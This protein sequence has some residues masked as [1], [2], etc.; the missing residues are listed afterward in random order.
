MAWHRSTHGTPSGTVHPFD[1][2]M[3]GS[4]CLA[5][6]TCAIG[7]RYYVMITT[8]IKFV[9]LCFHCYP[10]CTSWYSEQVPTFV[11]QRIGK[12]YLYAESTSQS[13]RKLR[14]SYVLISNQVIWLVAPDSRNLAQVCDARQ[15]KPLINWR[16]S[17]ARLQDANSPVNGLKLFQNALVATVNDVT[18]HHHGLLTLNMSRYRVLLK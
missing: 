4:V 3:K 9:Y 1:L 12:Y 13:T 16:G 5:S 6:W 10:W 2:K 15:N 17:R 7:M 14:T 8:Q 18:V 11:W